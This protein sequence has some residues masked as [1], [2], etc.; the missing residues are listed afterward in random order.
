MNK[1][2]LTDLSNA[3][4]GYLFLDSAKNGHVYTY[5]LAH[6]RVRDDRLPSFLPLQMPRD[7]TSPFFDDSTDEWTAASKESSYVVVRVSDPAQPIC[8]S[9]FPL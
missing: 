3:Y 6:L 5:Y 8:A 1:I 9:S 4:Q 2:R 7:G